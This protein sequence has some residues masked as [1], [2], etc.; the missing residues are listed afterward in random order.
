MKTISLIFQIFVRNIISS[1][2]VSATTVRVS[3]S[4]YGNDVNVLNFLNDVN[5][6]GGVPIHPKPYSQ[7]KLSKEDI[8][9]RISASSPARGTRRVGHAL[10]YICDNVFQMKTLSFRSVPK[11]I[12]VISGG[13]SVDVIPRDLS[14]FNQATTFNESQH[15]VS[16]IGLGLGSNG[17]NSLSSN[18]VSKILP[19]PNF[20]SVIILDN[21]VFDFI[22]GAAVYSCP[23][24]NYDL[25]FLLD[26]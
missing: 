5:E 18:A 8:L 12:V 10:S 22:C 13:E 17:V 20:A 2:D 6:V 25:V 3:A 26:G 1:Y 14:C 9:N 21:E 24:G 16:I 19:M 11:I 4:M 7:T 23:V 15:H